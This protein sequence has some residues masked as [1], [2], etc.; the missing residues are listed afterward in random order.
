[1]SIT[2]VEG[3]RSKDLLGN[4]TFNS[5]ARSEN[6]QSASIQ[7]NPTHE[8]ACCACQGV[9]RGPPLEERVTLCRLRKLEVFLLQLLAEVWSFKQLL[10]NRAERLHFQGGGLAGGS[11]DNSQSSEEYRKENDLRSTASC[12]PY[13]PFS[14]V[15]HSRQEGMSATSSP[16]L[17]RVSE[18]SAITKLLSTSHVIDICVEATVTSLL[19][20]AAI[21]IAALVSVTL[22]GD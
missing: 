7:S 4:T 5:F 12:V 3:Y 16:S 22:R 2:D 11:C 17:D 20:E 15:L 13:K 19:L 10:W 9:Q 21:A 18:F 6:L 8:Q 14:L 1:M